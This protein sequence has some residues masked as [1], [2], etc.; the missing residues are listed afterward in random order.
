[1]MARIANRH[2][3]QLALG[4]SV[5]LLLVPEI[6]AQDSALPDSAFT[7]AQ[8]RHDPIDVDA[9]PIVSRLAVSLVQPRRMLRDGQGNLYVA[10][11]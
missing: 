9:R 7:P 11:W 10:D 4:L 6:G 1:M 3:R 2:Y 8:H 5:V